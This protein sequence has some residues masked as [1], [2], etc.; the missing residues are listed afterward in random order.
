LNEKYINELLKVNK[1]ILI[2]LKSANI[3]KVKEVLRN[4]LD[5]P[6]KIVAYHHSTGENNRAKVASLSD[7]SGST[8]SEW[9]HSCIWRGIVEPVNVQRSTR[10]KKLFEI[11][12]FG[13]SIQIGPEK[14][15]SAGTSAPAAI[16]RKKAAEYVKETKGGEGL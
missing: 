16:G 14:D 11:E 9:W 12:D 15:E 10:A 4:I 5:S 13:K 7:S 8:I 2:W 3:G 1:E 6:D